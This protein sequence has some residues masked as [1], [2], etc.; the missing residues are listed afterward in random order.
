MLSALAEF[1][2][3]IKTRIFTREVNSA[4]IYLVT[5]FVNGVET[6]VIVDDWFP[7]I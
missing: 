3:R 1:P 5:L 4:G 2:D 6:P 7:S